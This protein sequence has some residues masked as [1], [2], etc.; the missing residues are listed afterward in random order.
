MLTRDSDYL[1]L[2]HR[3]IQSGVKLVH[4]RFGFIAH[5]GKAERG[6][7]DFSIAA[8]NQK[9]LVFDE[10]LQF[11]HVHDATAGTRSVADA[12]ERDGFKALF[13]EQIEPMPGRPGVCESG[14]SLVT[15]KARVD[16]KST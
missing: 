15:G 12:G 8:V 1:Q 4:R 5:V 9:A 13:R 11:R 2:L 6:A 7:F 10:L 14:K 16:R 3:R